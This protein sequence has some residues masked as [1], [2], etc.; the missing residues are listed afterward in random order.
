MRRDGGMQSFRPKEGKASCRKRGSDASLF[1]VRLGN[2]EKKQIYPYQN[3]KLNIFLKAGPTAWPLTRLA[4]PPIALST[5]RPAR[6]ALAILIPLPSKHMYSHAP[7]QRRLH[8]SLRSPVQAVR[9]LAHPAR[10]TSASPCPPKYIPKKEQKLVP[11]QGGVCD[12]T[13]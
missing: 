4:C 11:T 5:V 8:K 12:N 1:C 2:C 13:P 3:W 6:A 10:S 7:N 9:E